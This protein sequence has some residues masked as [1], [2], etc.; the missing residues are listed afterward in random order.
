MGRR[1]VPLLIHPKVLPNELIP[2][3]SADEFGP[4]DGGDYIYHSVFIGYFYIGTVSA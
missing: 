1:L 3:N 4:T 2:G